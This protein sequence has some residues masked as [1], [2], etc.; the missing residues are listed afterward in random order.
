MN[1]PGPLQRKKAKAISKAI[2]FYK[3]QSYD[4]SSAWK[5]TVIDNMLLAK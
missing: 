1:I 4:P 3:A 2:P 5:Q